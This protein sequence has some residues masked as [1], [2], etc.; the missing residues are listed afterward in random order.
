MLPMWPQAT[1][2]FS[3]EPR[4]PQLAQQVEVLSPQDLVAARGSGG[5]REQSFWVSLAA[6]GA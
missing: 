3:P 1:D 5:R 6:G 2:H 4:A